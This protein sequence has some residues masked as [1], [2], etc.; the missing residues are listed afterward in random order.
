MFDEEV[1]EKNQARKKSA[2]STV[3]LIDNAS[4]MFPSRPFGLMADIRG[5]KE[6]DIKLTRKNAY[7]DVLYFLNSSLIYYTGA[8]NTEKFKNQIAIM[9]TAFLEGYANGMGQYKDSFKIW[10]L[11]EGKTGFMNLL[12]TFMENLTS[13]TIGF[14][15]QYDKGSIFRNALNIKLKEKFSPDKKS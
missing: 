7:F 1:F 12:C 14:W 11:D 3:T 9:V 13:G 10:L 15:G 5:L 6:K 2:L 8:I 4:F